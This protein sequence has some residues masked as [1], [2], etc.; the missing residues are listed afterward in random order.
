MQIMTGVE[1]KSATDII[2][3]FFP[4][5]S[6]IVFSSASR[7]FDLA[8]SYFRKSLALYVVQVVRE[9]E[10][11]LQHFIRRKEPTVT[12]SSFNKL[13]HNQQ[14]FS[15]VRYCISYFM[16]YGH[17]YSTGTVTCMSASLRK[18]FLAVGDL[19]ITYAPK[20]GDF[21]L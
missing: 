16:F 15:P 2:L 7:I 12:K 18:A 14:S 11:N 20:F 13:Q 19:C 6:Q 17:L 5:F 1:G 9:I 10:S 3:N 4:S 21:E 8:S